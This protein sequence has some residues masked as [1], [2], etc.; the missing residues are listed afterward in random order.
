MFDGDIDAAAKATKISKALSDMNTHKAHDRHLHVDECIS[1]GL[2]I[3]LL[4]DGQNLQDALLTVHHCY[5]HSLSVTGASKIVENHNGA[6]FIKV[7]A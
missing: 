3:E 5:M 7:T 6:A 1:L 4:E 2:K